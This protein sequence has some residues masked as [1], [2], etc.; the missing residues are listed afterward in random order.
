VTLPAR[1]L[2]V[3]AC[4]AFFSGGALHAQGTTQLSGTAAL[5]LPYSSKWTFVGEINPSGVIA[6]SPGWRQ[7]GL[8]VGAERRVHPHI[9]L[10]GYAY[11]YYT[12]QLEDVN[13]TE[14]R[15]RLGVLPHWRLRPRWFLQGR[16]VVES[17]WMFYQNLDHDLTVRGRLRAL[18][19]YTIR[20]PNEYLPGAIF[21]RGDIEGFIPLGEKATERYFDKVAL[22]AGMGY[23]FSRHDLGELNL[24]NRASTTTVGTGRENVDWIIEMK[25]THVLSRLTPPKPTSSP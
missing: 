22:R 20:R 8:D 4:A 25:Y 2:R 11:G 17:R 24:V 13:T 19:R 12:N 15:L 3:L 5:V 16:A 21:L 1:H 6:G 18:T 9:D 10:L 7:F 23:R 14:L